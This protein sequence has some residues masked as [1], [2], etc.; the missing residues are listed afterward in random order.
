MI[1]L[2]LLSLFLN[3]WEEKTKTI[4]PYTSDLAHA[5]SNLQAIAK[6]SD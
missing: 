2:K 1:G 5:G 4:A 6:K 3:Q